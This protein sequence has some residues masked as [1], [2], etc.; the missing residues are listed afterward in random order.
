MGPTNKGR[1]KH[2]S[3]KMPRREDEEGLVNEASRAKEF[4]G[5]SSLKK[6][7]K[8]KERVSTR[9]VIVEENRIWMRS[10][11]RLNKIVEELQEEEGRGITLIEAIKEKCPNIAVTLVD[12]LQKIVR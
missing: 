4:G 8:E 7:R 6:I 3:P 11:K 9:E 2:Y 1:K 12:I 5:N 10:T